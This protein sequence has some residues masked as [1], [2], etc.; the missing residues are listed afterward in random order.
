[1]KI[2]IC[3]ETY[4]DWSFEETFRH[5]SE[6]GYAGIEIAPFT[7]HKNAFEIS[8]DQVAHIVKLSKQFNLELVGLHWLLAYTNGLHLNSPETNTRRRTA[9]YLGQLAQVCARLGGQIMVLGSPS[10]RNIEHGISVTQANDLA[11]DCIQRVV[12][13]LERNG[14]ILALE[15]LGPDEGNFMLTA[16]WGRQLV[17]EINSRSVRLHLDVKA[18]STESV[19][20]PEIISASKDELI[21]FHANDPN[22]R[23]PGM[24]DVH[25]EP[26]IDAL[27]AIQYD[28]WLSVEVFD[29]TVPPETTAIESRLYLQNQLRG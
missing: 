10:Q 21:H 20:I 28:G 4:R 19:S 14:I 29:E 8:A 23:G 9:E 22:R 2:A 11:I 18:M 3:N 25:Y 26:I 12:P 7:L 24:G 15:P 27:R 16:E 13:V 1:M 17:R 6:S 5:A